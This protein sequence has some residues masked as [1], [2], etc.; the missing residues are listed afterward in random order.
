[1]AESAHQVIARADAFNGTTND[2]TQVQFNYQGTA[3]TIDLDPTNAAEFDAAVAPFIKV[4]R[5]VS[6]RYSRD[7]PGPPA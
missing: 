1:M 5:R 3:Y 6:P 2:V 4:G 7:R